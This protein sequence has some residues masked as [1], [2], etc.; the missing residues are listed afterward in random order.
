MFKLYERL[1][2]Y[3][4]E[5]KKYAY[6]SM[7]LSGIA[8]FIYMAAYWYLWKALISILVNFDLSKG[9]SYSIN[10][11]VLMIV[12][13]ILAVSSLLASHFLGFRLET[14][15]RK[16]GLYKLLDASFSFFDRNNSGQVRKIIDDNAGNTHKTMAHL[17]PDMVTALLTPLCMF[18][19]TFLVDFRLGILL[20][21][22]CIMGVFQYKKMYGE[23]DLMS[24]FTKTLE[25]MSASTVEYVRGMQVIKLFGVSVEYY[26]SLINSIKDYKTNVYAYSQSCRKPYVGFQVLFNSF[27]AF[28]VPVV[29]YLVVKDEQIGLMLAKLT[30][31]TIFS[32]IAFSSFMGIMFAAT[33]NFSAE[34]TINTLENLMKEMD[35]EKLKYGRL[36]IMNDYDIEFNDVS[37]KYEENFVLK[38]FNLKLDTGK[39][40]ALVGPS[41]SGKS[42]IAK[43]ISGFYPVDSGKILIGGKNIVDYSEKAI[44]ENIA[45]VFQHA[46]LF[47]QSI[48]D[49]VL[50]GNPKA[51]KEDVLNALKLA[52]CDSI[53]N[54]FPERENTI[55]GSKGV[56]LSGGE[57]QRIAIARAILKDAKI[58]IMDEALAATDPDNEFEIQQ[59]FSNLIKGK[60]VIMIAHRL[61]TI[62][63]VDEILFVENG[64]IIERGN[65]KTLMNKGGRYKTLQDMYVCTNKWRIA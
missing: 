24:E 14:N 51:S 48:Y 36:D 2:D 21:L 15:L 10:V 16:A 42:T 28:I 63:N 11:V 6:I 3:V 52:S 27:Y 4:P 23:P 1:F 44:Q 55:I 40:Y 25:K 50:I 58:V 12:R 8:I 47:K 61:S 65:H 39:I 38:N 41:G 62:T 5:R 32:G 31:F 29:A 22:I 54:K 18:V 7:I 19:L 57:I 33:D 53:L 35:E 9:I 46:K 30:F 60:T 56:Y 49:N 13:G 45:F 59:A 43:L 26:K 17:I 20:V 34:L 64:E 37:F